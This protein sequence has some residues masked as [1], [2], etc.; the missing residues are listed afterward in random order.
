MHLTAPSP[1]GC[2]CASG[3]TGGDAVIAAYSSEVAHASGHAVS[4]WRS[5]TRT[6]AQHEEMARWVPL[7]GF[8]PNDSSS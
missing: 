2:G 6:S 4:Y 8:A 5:R 3:G 1:T 7:G